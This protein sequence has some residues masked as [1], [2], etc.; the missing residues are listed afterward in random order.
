MFLSLALYEVA[1][2]HLDSFAIEGLKIG[3]PE[4]GRVYTL[5]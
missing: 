1:R 5:L 4:K 2:T 3:Q